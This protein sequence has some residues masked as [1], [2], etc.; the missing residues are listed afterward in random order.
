[1]ISETS[2][3]WLNPGPGDLLIITKMLQKIQEIMESSW[4]NIIYVNMG[5]NK[6]RKSSEQMY[7]LGANFFFVLEFLSTIFYRLFC[8]IFYE[9]EDGKMLHFP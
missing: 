6:F 8:I 4:T 9:G 3:I 5:L 2:N 1:M 7:V